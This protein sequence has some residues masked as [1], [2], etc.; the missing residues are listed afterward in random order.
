MARLRRNTGERAE[1][2][3]IYEA[4]REAAVEV[5]L[6]MDRR[7]AQLEARVEQLERRLGRSLRNPSL[8]PSQDPPNASRRRDKDHSGPATRRAVWA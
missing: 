5:R 8:P 3:A 1:A 7:I 4:R 2:E 6:A